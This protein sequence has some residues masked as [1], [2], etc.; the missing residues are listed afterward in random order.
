MTKV[1]EVIPLMPKALPMPWVKRV[2]PAPSGPLIRIRSPAKRV[3]PS[4]APKANIS[5]GVAIAITGKD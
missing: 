3:P 5:S 2:L 4:F 1:G